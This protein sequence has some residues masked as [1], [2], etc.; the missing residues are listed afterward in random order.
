MV[1]QGSVPEAALA[2]PLWPAFET[3]HA[4]VYFTP[5]AAEARLVERGWLA[6]GSTFTEAGRAGRQ[7]VAPMARGILAVGG[8]PVPNPVGVPAL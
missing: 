8:V 6:P 4:T 5:E 7:A 2:R 1:T 3:Y